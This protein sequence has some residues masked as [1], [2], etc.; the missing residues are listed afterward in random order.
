MAVGIPQLRA[1]VAVVDAGGFGAAADRLGISQSA[2]S[3]A[4]A[5]LE[6][7][8][9]R[10][11]L[12][13]H[14]R[15]A[16]TRF[17]EQIL[18]HARTVLASVAAIDALAE[19]GTGRPRGALTI[20]APPT[21][22]HGLLPELVL[23]WRAEFPEVAVSLFEGEDD[24][25]AGWLEGGTADLAVLI[26][27]PAPPAGSALVGTDRFHAV[28]RTDHPLAAEPTVDIADLADD[29]FLLSSGGCERQIQE[30]HRMADTPFR[31][32]HRIRQLSTLF[33]MVRSG[34][35]VSVLPGLAAGMVGPDLVLVPLRQSLTRTLVLTGP[36]HRP[37]HPAARAL[38]EASLAVP[39][40]LAGRLRRTPVPPGARRH[41]GIPEPARSTESLG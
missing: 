28:L 36:L 31:P 35:G 22:C 6:R 32:A 14:G 39:P 8:T 21:I 12:T 27:P 2:V 16:L 34:V 29:D 4:V 40:P 18:D 9:G 13:R 1:F 38:V 15:P 25:V 5:A 37:W 23:R 11:V 10:P 17:G 20:A 24:E 33:A 30:L 26:D 7:A 19:D 3:H 41:P